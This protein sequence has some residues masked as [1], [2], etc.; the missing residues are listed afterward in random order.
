MRFKIKKKRPKTRPSPPIATS[1]PEDPDI[2]AGVE[3]AISLIGSNE[4]KSRKN[5]LESFANSQN[6]FLQ[7]KGASAATSAGFN[8][9][10]A[11]E[12]RSGWYI[13]QAELYLKNPHDC[14]LPQCA[15]ILPVFSRL[16][17]RLND[18]IRIPG[19]TERMK[20]ALT[21]I[22]VDI[23]STLFEL[24]VASA[25]LRRGFSDVA[26]VPE[27]SRVKTPDIKMVRNGQDF[28][29]ECK[30]KRKMSDYARK[31][32]EQWWKLS[33]RLRQKL[34]NDKT[35]VLIDFVFHIPLSECPA[36]YLD[37]KV[38]PLIKGERYGTLI[39]DAELSVSLKPVHLQEVREVFRTTMIRVDS[40]VLYEK[41][42][43]SFERWR[44]YTGSWVYHPSPTKPRYITDITFATGCVWSCDASDTLRNKAQHFRRE[45][46]QAVEQLPP[47]VPSAV[48]LGFEAYDGEG[49][50]AIRYKRLKDEMM[51]GFNSGTKNL[52]MV[53]CNLFEFESTPTEN[54]AVNETCNYWLKDESSRSYLL[55]PM[56]LLAE[57]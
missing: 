16:G 22:G 4:W 28:Y 43:G 42:Y 48:H 47:G 1:W 6:P 25:Y 13:Y 27:S 10:V 32:R 24:I 52:E 50:E 37:R 19:A 31:E 3:W 56:L 51:G 36:D 49:V 55:E 12:D 9:P 57:P 44:G 46:A 11:P 38:T 20:R 35:S 33:E 15:R 18:I 34:V 53:Y 41:L 54:W 30:R 26:F 17:N 21:N 40:P 5:V 7:Y 2:L 45:L 29:A 39:D 23:D 14:D 8:F